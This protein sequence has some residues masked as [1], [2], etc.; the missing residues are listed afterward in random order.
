MIVDCIQRLH[1][2]MA[3]A[4]LTCVNRTRDEVRAL[5]EKIPALGCKNILALRGDPPCR[6]TRGIAVS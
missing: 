1:G 4:H 2:L 6:T 5:L 3:L